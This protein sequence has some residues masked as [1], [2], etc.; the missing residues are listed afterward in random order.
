MSFICIPFLSAEY[1][2]LQEEFEAEKYALN[3]ELT[4]AKGAIAQLETDILSLEVDLD[5]LRAEEVQLNADK[6]VLRGEIKGL[7]AEISEKNDQITTEK[8]KNLEL[9]E[10]NAIMVRLR[11]C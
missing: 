6:E 7:N 10:C 5:K 3:V 2:K 9:G 1:S 11:T 8:E 4:T